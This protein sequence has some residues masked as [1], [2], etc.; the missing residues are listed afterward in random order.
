MRDLDLRKSSVTSPKSQGCKFTLR[1]LESL[2]LTK[3]LLPPIR[4][5]VNIRH[6]NENLD[7]FLLKSQG[8]ES[9]IS[10]EQYFPKLISIER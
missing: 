6:N 7:I 10:L 3:I 9:L 8:M 5:Y 2:I 4:T 1:L